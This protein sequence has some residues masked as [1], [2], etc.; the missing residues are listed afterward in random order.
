[1]QVSNPRIIKMPS[2]DNVSIT[3]LLDTLQLDTIETEEEVTDA[4]KQLLS[5]G[6]ME[7]KIKLTNIYNVIKNRIRTRTKSK[8]TFVVKIKVNCKK[9]EK[10]V[11]KNGLKLPTGKIKYTCSR[12]KG[13]LPLIDGCKKCNST[14]ILTR[15]CPVCGGTT[16]VTL[17]RKVGNNI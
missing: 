6:T 5:A 4:Y 9:C 16:Q 12:C 17:K 10:L 7:D 2:F 11:L 1:M 15:A 3:S 8:N 13:K 14:G